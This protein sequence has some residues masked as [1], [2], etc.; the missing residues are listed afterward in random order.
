MPLVA[1]RIVHV[2]DHAAAATNYHRHELAKIMPEDYATAVL[3]KRERIGRSRDM[4]EEQRRI[5]D[6]LAAK[7]GVRR[8]HAILVSDDLSAYELNVSDNGAPNTVSLAEYRLAK[9]YGRVIANKL[10]DKGDVA[11]LGND[12]V[13]AEQELRNALNNDDRATAQRKIDM[14][15][16]QLAV[17]V[18][19]DEDR[20]YIVDVDE[21]LRGM[22]QIAQDERAPSTNTFPYMPERVTQYIIDDSPRELFRGQSVT[23]DL[24][25]SPARFDLVGARWTVRTVGS[26]D[27]EVINTDKLSLTLHNV[28]R[29]RRVSAV[30]AYGNRLRDATTQEIDVIVRAPCMRCG[31]EIVVGVDDK[32]DP[33]ACEWRLKRK[34]DD[35]PL[36]LRPEQFRLQWHYTYCR[37]VNP[38][39][40][41][42]VDAAL[43]RVLRPGQPRART[44]WAIIAFMAIQ[45][46]EYKHDATGEAVSQF[47]ALS[48]IAGRILD[49]L[50]VQQLQSPNGPIYVDNNR[51]M[52][53]PPR[54][55]VGARDF[56]NKVN[57]FF[58]GQSA[59]VTFVGSHS[60]DSA[61]PDLLGDGSD[62]ASVIRGPLSDAMQ[63]W[64]RE[65]ARTGDDTIKTRYNEMFDI[66]RLYI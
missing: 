56:D 4:L 60:A 63:H 65:Y 66:D 6:G 40:D 5:R 13:L 23:I 48:D 7:Y 27:V 2:S 19:T 15:D 50:G 47:T 1:Q 14:I 51:E 31:N 55:S 26:D 16:D 57:L 36:Q 8:A 10:V 43:K 45:H 34:P 3:Q 29:T 62:H 20:H 12:K 49:R 52:L 59:Y 37:S 41:R 22:Q 17:H 30:A 33:W 64:I 58:G 53:D 9:R 61:L 18:L 28:Q 24:F 46:W 44:R 32:G 39:F 54:D 25:S 21:A 42:Q 35:L 38:N 11:R